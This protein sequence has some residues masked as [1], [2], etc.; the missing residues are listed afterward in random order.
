MT[1][2]GTDP[3]EHGPVDDLM[4]P[5]GEP[6]PSDWTEVEERDFVLVLATCHS[7][8]AEDLMVA[9]D[10]R[11]D[12]GHIHL[13]YVTAGVSRPALLRIFLAMEKGT[14]LACDCPHLVYR[15]VRALRLEPVT[16]PGVI[17]V[18]GEQVEYGPIQVQVHRGHARL[19]SG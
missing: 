17:T 12:D 8:L 13:F 18:D 19:I 14:H 10:T 15:R 1:H 16:R 4:I 2:T 7:H 11:P 9:P 6:I 5:P 3:K